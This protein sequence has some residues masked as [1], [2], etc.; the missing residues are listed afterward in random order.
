MTLA[1]GRYM[2]LIA[3]VSPLAM[4]TPLGAQ[5]RTLLADQPAS[6][7]RQRIAAL[8]RPTAP[9]GLAAAVGVI[10]VIAALI[11]V[12]PFVRDDGLATPGAAIAAAER[13]HLDG[14]VFNDQ[15]YGGFLI[16]RG[17]KPFIDGRMEMYGEAF[18]S[19]YMKATGGEK[20]VLDDVLQRYGIT[21][22]LLQPEDG[23]VAVLD[24]MAGW[25]R[26]YADDYAVV[27][28]RVGAGAADAA[29]AQ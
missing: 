26:V 27:H 28:A 19:R 20:T 25:R 2:D 12:E 18:L 8:A 5:F 4:A 21:W 29:P 22:T 15:A 1:H 7:L 16:F 9:A 11:S 13:S 10:V 14:P 6:A 17:I 3:L 23:A 24:H